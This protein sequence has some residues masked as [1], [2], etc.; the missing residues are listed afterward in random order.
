MCAVAY[1]EAVLSESRPFENLGHQIQRGPEGKRHILILQHAPPFLTDLNAMSLSLCL[2]LSLSLSLF[3]HFLTSCTSS[4]RFCTHRNSLEGAGV[5]GPI[6]L[7][8]D[9]S[10]VVVEIL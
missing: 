5:H 8:G 9:I 6:D 2:S 10:V 7:R 4:S 1:L 3:L